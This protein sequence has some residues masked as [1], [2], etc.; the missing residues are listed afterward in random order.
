[1]DHFDH[2]SGSIVPIHS[3]QVTSASDEDIAVWDI[4]GASEA[5]GFLGVVPVGS[6]NV[7]GETKQWQVDDPSGTDEVGFVHALLAELS[8]TYSVP[9]SGPRIAL[10]FSGGAAMATLLGCHNSD[11]FYVA[12]MG[13]HIHPSSTQDQSVC[14]IEASPCP[15]YQA[16]GDEDF[17]ITSLQPTPTEGI[18]NQYETLRDSVGCPSESTTV[19]TESGYSCYTYH[20]DCN[21]CF[22]PGNPENLKIGDFFENSINSD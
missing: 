17:F 16:I 1:M 9:S 7:G 2:M 11:N 13:T 21:G 19:S 4:P 20:D 3:T 14:G 8:T 18:M 6:M 12:H 10:G 5:Y 22:G 15:E